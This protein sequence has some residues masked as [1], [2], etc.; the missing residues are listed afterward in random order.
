MVSLPQG[1]RTTF[2]RGRKIMVYPRKN[3]VCRGVCDELESN[4]HVENTT[5]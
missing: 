4:Y 2:Y 3:T 1:K 5:W